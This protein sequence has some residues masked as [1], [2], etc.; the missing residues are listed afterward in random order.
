[1]D[2]GELAFDNLYYLLYHV[3]NI[4]YA[5][6]YI[7]F[8]YIFR[9]E[10]HNMFCFTHSS[11]PTSHAEIQSIEVRQSVEKHYRTSWLP[12]CH[13]QTR[14]AVELEKIFPRVSTRSKDH[15][16]AGVLV[17]LRLGAAA[18]GADVPCAPSP[19]GAVRLGLTGKQ[20]FKAFCNS[21][22]CFRV[23]FRSSAS[24][25]KGCSAVGA[26]PSASLRLASCASM[27]ERAAAYQLCNLADTG[28]L[29]TNSS[30]PTLAC[31][32]FSSQAFRE[33]SACAKD[34]TALAAVVAIL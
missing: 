25:G 4:H 34:P 32:A 26:T 13:T 30:L 21:D 6:M 14:D 29:T 33:D 28:R 10:I 5:Y 23:A 19:A 15:A 11:F 1:M 18:T 9:M 24:Q 27:A 7:L 17:R 20:L 3:E 12:G 8:V 16:Q 22:T 2:P 31:S